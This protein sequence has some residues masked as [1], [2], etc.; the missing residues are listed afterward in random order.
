MCVCGRGKAEIGAGNSSA[1]TRPKG[2]GVSLGLYLFV[3]VFQCLR[4]LEV[5]TQNMC[6]LG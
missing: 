1:T 3:E 5:Y 6:K 2:L 4:D